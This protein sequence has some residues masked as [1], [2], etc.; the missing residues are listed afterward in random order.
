LLRVAGAPNITMSSL[1]DDFNEN[2]ALHDAIKATSNT[3]HPSALTLSEVLQRKGA[4]MLTPQR[5]NSKY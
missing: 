3:T 4:S 5:K 1:L 2:S